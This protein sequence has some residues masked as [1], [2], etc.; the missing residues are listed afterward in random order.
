M[1]HKCTTLFLTVLLPFF[2]IADQQA[3]KILGGEDEKNENK[4]DPFEERMFTL[5]EQTMAQPSGNGGASGWISPPAAASAPTQLSG[6]DELRAKVDD[7][8][9]I[10]SSLT[11]MKKTLECANANVPDTI[12]TQLAS[13]TAAYG[14][15]IQ[16]LL[17]ATTGESSTVLS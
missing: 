11:E 16:K 5:L 9:K 8:A 10:V 17:D 7:C 2:K 3:L 1:F 13:A 15:A 6:V 4:V 12:E 14:T